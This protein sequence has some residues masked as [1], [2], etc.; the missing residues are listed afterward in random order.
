MAPMSPGALKACLLGMFWG[1]VSVWG[2]GTRLH[3]GM[4]HFVMWF[5]LSWCRLYL[6]AV[7]HVEIRK[8]YFLHV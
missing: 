7:Y 1:G 6:N 2:G 8:I 3:E 5:I 4:S